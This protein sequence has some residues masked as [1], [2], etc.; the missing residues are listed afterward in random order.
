M[1]GAAPKASVTV[2]ITAENTDMSGVVKSSNPALCAADRKVVVWKQKGERG[3][4]DDTRFASDTTDLQNG[5]YV[6]STGNTGTAG[7][8]YAKVGSTPGCKADSSPTIRVHRS[9]P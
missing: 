8:F 6:W 4:G 1:A 9:S 5:K 7:R 3:G 2:T